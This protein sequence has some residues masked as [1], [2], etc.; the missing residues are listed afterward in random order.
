[1]KKRLKNKTKPRK[2][3]DNWIYGYHAVISAI[4]NDNRVKYRLILDQ[5]AKKKIR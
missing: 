1:M 4:K 5:G 2:N 3:A